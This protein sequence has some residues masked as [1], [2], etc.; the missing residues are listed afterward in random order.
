[1]PYHIYRVISV[2]PV[3]QL[4][5]L[6]EHE[7]FKTASAQAKALRKE[8]GLPAGAE[9]KVIFADNELLAEELLSQVRE[10]EPF[11]GDDY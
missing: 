2:G 10:P 7:A 3:R 5:K 1:M 8:G 4:E 11:I 6:A 9:I